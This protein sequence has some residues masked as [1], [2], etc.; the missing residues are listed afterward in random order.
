MKDEEDVKKM[1]IAYYFN[2]VE[3]LAQIY[4]IKYGYLPQFRQDDHDTKK[5]KK[6]K[7]FI[8]WKDLVEEDKK[9]YDLV[10]RDE[11]NLRKLIEGWF[12][13]KQSLLKEENNK[14]SIIN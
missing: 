13:K 10:F 8:F 1:I 11:K 6:P 4:K 7:L 5:K 3:R 14:Y 2:R 12:Q 9:S